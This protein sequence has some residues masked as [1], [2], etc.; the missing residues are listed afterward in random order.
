MEKFKYYLVL[1]RCLGFVFFPNKSEKGNRFIFLWFVPY[2][3]VYLYF[4]TRGLVLL[5][6]EAAFYSNDIEKIADIGIMC[7]STLIANLRIYYYYIKRNSFRNL[8]AKLDEFD[9]RFKLV[10]SPPRN[11]GRK[12]LLFFFCFVLVLTADLVIAKIN[13]ESYFLFYLHTNNIRLL[14][15]HEFFIHEIPT[16]L[17]EQLQFTNGKIL[18]VS[19]SH[20]TSQNYLMKTLREIIKLRY[21][22]INICEETNDFF[23][24]IALL[25][26]TLSLIILILWTYFLKI[27]KLPEDYLIMLFIEIWVVIAFVLLLWF[28]RQLTSIEKEVSFVCFRNNYVNSSFSENENVR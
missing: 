7:L 14:M 6:V 27:F 4:T 15:F 25:N 2:A 20:V 24:P 13:Y 1:G 17:L 5:H 11:V 16:K 19:R 12:F 3:I 26:T 28:I 8:L 23:G 18:N 22:S 21:E 10:D 9:N